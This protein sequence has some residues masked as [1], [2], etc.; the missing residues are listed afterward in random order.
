MDYCTFIAKQFEE[1]N[2]LMSFNVH[3]IYKIEQACCSVHRGHIINIFYLKYIC[4]K[5]TLL[6]NPLQERERDMRPAVGADRRQ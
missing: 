2:V 1:F 6:N 4:Y 3:P 5:E